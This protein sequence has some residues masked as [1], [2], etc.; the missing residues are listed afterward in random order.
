MPYIFIGSGSIIYT[1]YEFVNNKEWISFLIVLTYFCH[2]SE[3]L[4]HKRFRHM[5][6]HICPLLGDPT[7]L[8]SSKNQFV[9]I[10][11]DEGEEGPL[12]TS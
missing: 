9:Q 6:W 5:A 3:H 11:E 7:I 2:L 12:G 8:D 1:A 4:A 10:D